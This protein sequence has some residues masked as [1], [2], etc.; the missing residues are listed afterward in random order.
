M[1]NGVN[2]GP[3]NP[4]IPLGGDISRSEIVKQLLKGQKRGPLLTPGATFADIGTSALKAL[5]GAM[6]RQQGLDADT[7][8]TK[9]FAEA[10]AQREE[11][12]APFQGP[13]DDPNR[14]LDSLDQR[15]AGELPPGEF[16][17]PQERQAM[18]QALN[19]ETRAAL[20]PDPT[21]DRF[22]FPPVPPTQRQPTQQ[23]IAQVLLQN[24]QNRQLGGQLLLQGQQAQQAGDVRG[25][26]Q[27]FQA[28]QNRLG[29]EATLQAAQGRQGFTAEQAQL[30]REFKAE[31]SEIAL[32]SKTQLAQGKQVSTAKQKE[33]AREFVGSENKL[34]RESRERVADDNRKAQLIRQDSLNPLEVR[35]LAD[36]DK[37]EQLRGRKVRNAFTTFTRK[38]G[39]LTRAIDKALGQM[40]FLAT[41]IPGAVFANLPASQ[42]KNLRSTLDTIKANVGFDELQAMRSNSPTGGALGQVSENENKLLQSVQASLD[43]EQG[44]DQLRENLNIVKQLAAEL[45]SEREGAFNTD[46]S[47]QPPRRNRR[48]TD[49]LSGDEQTELEALE[50]EFGGR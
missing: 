39:N 22:A 42:A 46:F 28:E 48:S 40:T 38:N 5:S 44:V 16:G 18:A 49:G 47:D 11:P 29:R 30:G 37:K 9:N 27:Q 3:G 15:F 45:F 7:A 20:Q 24:P 23:E 12:G 14:A 41:G 26:Q 25:Q 10:F 6:L 17:G 36:L 50:R 33:L 21:G 2:L 8:A 13:L 31:Q 19:Q 43:P 4:N 35:K 34:N 1:A 32:D